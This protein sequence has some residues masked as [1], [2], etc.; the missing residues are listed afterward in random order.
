ME[1]VYAEDDGPAV[2]MWRA[3]GRRE[4]DKVMV[5]GTERTP[6]KGSIRIAAGPS[7]VV[8]SAAA[9]AENTDQKNIRRTTAG[10]SSLRRYTGFRRIA[11]G[12]RNWERE[13]ERM[14]GEAGEE[15]DG[16]AR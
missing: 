12:R 13:G 11:W 16:Q 14:G 6:R 4:H 3:A 10:P 7:I 8:E 9:A 2:G 5:E 1:S 15:K